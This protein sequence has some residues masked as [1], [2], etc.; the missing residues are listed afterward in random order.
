MKILITLICD[1]K[2]LSRDTSCWPV[3]SFGW[4]ALAESSLSEILGL[5]Y[6]PPMDLL[7][8]WC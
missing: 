5:N 1:G 2:A 7:G 6:N 8:S 4:Y 3:V